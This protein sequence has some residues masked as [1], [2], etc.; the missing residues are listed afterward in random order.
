MG[1][2]SAVRVRVVQRAGGAL[3]EAHARHVVAVLGF[4]QA[5]DGLGELEGA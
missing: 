3:D 1:L 5:R 4:P 2:S